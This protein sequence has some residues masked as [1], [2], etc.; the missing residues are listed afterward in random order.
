[1]ARKTGKK[2]TLLMID[3]DADFTS[4]FLMLLEEYFECFSATDSDRGINI[5]RERSIDI[6]LLDLM[7]DNGP[8]GIEILRKIKKED[9]DLPVIM[10]TDYASVDTVIE[11]MRN[12]AYDYVSKTPNLKELLLKIQ[13][14]IDLSILKRKTASLRELAIDKYRII[15]ESPA[16]KKLR[17]K[18][19]LYAGNLN[20]VLIT[21]ESGV[22]K[23]L[24][25]RQIH[26]G[27][28]YKKEPFVAINCAAIPRE[29]IE[30]ELFGH[31]KGA[32]TGAVKQKLGKFEIASPGTIFLDEI[33]ELNPEAQVKLLRVI[34]NREFERVGGHKTIENKARIIAA[35]NRN[36]EELI[37]ENRFREDLYYRLDV[38][39]IEVP[40][41]RGRKEDIPALVEYFSEQICNDL[42]T[43]RKTFSPRA[44]E[45]MMNY[46]WP[47]NIRELQNH[48]TRAIISASGNTVTND[49]LDQKLTGNGG[50]FGIHPD[51]IPETWEEM[52]E[53]RKEA[54]DRVSRE[55]EK[56]FLNNLLKKFDGS[57]ARAAENIGIN[58]ASLYKMLKK[59][60]LA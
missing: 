50:F 44:L 52:N 57:I 21:G 6:I 26:F 34:Q 17:E 20:T 16:V 12:G 18:I 36:L 2:L 15:G 43:G 54:A 46:D 10:I 41:L 25:A 23:E 60:G 29:L 53:M 58:R 31:E 39:P 32:F 42:K 30:S 51:K 33:S 38:L 56:L 45:T 47:G 24:V 4:D 7:F 55:I 28:A 19:S 5:M 59:C 13:K 9:P 1:M 14:S 27:S 37:R 22:G 49:D 11:A 8:N 35:T 3:D 40:P 48:V